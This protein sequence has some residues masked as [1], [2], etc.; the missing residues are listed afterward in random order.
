[1]EKFIY[2]FRGGVNNIGNPETMQATRQKWTHWMQLLAQNGS[3][4]GGEPLNRDGKQLSG[5]HKTVTDG[6]YTEAKEMVGGYL[7]VNA[8]DITHATEIAKGCPIF[9]EYTDGKVEV[10]QIQQMN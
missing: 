7:I 6:P 3:L 1:M 5:A 9:D 8:N 2:L 4:V 10:R